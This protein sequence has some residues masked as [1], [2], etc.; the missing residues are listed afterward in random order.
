MNNQ[1]LKEYKMYINPEGAR[2]YNGSEE[3][4]DILLNIFYEWNTSNSISDLC[5]KW[6]K[7]RPKTYIELLIR[8]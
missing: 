1:K 8:Y 3:E 4:K 2:N 6:I 7:V 5:E